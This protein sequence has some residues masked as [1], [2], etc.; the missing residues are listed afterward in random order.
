VAPTCAHGREEAKALKQEAG[1]TAQRWVVEC[2]HR[3]MHRSRHLLIRWDKRLQ[4]YLGFLHLTC[5]YSSYK[6]SGLLGSALR[7]HGHSS[8]SGVAVHD[9]SHVLHC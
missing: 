1:F 7:P 2:T 8:L 3:C 6:P 9:P 5:T 4:N